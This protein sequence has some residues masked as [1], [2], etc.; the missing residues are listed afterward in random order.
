MHHRCAANPDRSRIRAG[1]DA[2][3]R[4][5]LV[6]WVVQHN[7]C[8]K[9]ATGTVA[10]LLHFLRGS[11]TSLGDRILVCTHATLAHAYKRLKAHRQLAV[12]KDVVLWIDEGHHAKNAQIAGRDDTVSNSL[13]RWRPTV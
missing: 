7:L 9:Q 11:H 13:A 12:L 1:L 5:E 4:W 2:A 8:H 6:D 3:D 10:S